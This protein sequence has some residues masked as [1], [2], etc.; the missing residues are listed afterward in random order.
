MTPARSGTH[1]VNLFSATLCRFQKRPTALR[2][3]EPSALL[4]S[5]ALSPDPFAFRK[6]EAAYQ[7]GGLTILTVR[8]S[9]SVCPTNLLRPVSGYFVWQAPFAEHLSYL[10]NTALASFVCLHFAYPYRPFPG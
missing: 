6:T 10:P 9:Q 7:R 2:L 5:Q 8:G 1:G 4:A 3:V